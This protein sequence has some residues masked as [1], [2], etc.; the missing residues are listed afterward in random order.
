MVDASAGVNTLALELA[1]AHD[2]GHGVPVPM[3]LNPLADMRISC[4]GSGKEVQNPW[5][6]GKDSCV[7]VVVIGAMVVSSI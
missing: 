4:A 7:V 3:A 6:E 5:V 1:E 2:F